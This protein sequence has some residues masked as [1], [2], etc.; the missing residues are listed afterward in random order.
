MIMWFRKDKIKIWKMGILA[1]LAV[2]VYCGLITLLIW[3]G[4]D[5]LSDKMSQVMGSLFGL[6][7]LVFS[8]A[9]SGVLVFGYPLFLAVEKKYKQAFQAIGVTLLTIFV[10]LLVVLS[11]VLMSI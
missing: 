7:L 4:G 9:I 5:F 1:G 3:F 2:A 11:I 6:I 10:V 8:V